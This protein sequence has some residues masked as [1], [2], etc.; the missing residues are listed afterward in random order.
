MT[1][2]HRHVTSSEIQ[3][4]L[5]E[6]VRCLAIDTASLR[7]RVASAALALGKVSS[8]DFRATEDRWL[9]DRIR[10]A[11]MRLDLAEQDPDGPDGTRGDAWQ[12][13]L[14]SVASDIL[15]LRDLATSRAISEARLRA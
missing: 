6:A 9:I 2:P 14:E 3:D 13:A 10:L 11:L 5:D 7:E 1:P 12:E 15:D 8:E 4:A